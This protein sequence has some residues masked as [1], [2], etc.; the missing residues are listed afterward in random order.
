MTKVHFK[1]LRNQW[2]PWNPCQLRPCH[3]LTSLIRRCSFRR[4]HK[5]LIFKAFQGL[6]C[7][8]FEK[9]HNLG[10]RYFDQSISVASIV[11]FILRF[12]ITFFMQYFNFSV[13]F[14]TTVQ[15]KEYCI[16]DMNR[17]QLWFCKSKYILYMIWHFLVLKL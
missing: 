17:Y 4:I 6:L 5:L 15:Q 10:Y 13:K 1:L 8:S 3:F 12:C 9:V 2:V 7:T 14:D 11:N 16:E